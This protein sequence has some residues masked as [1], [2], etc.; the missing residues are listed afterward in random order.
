LIIVGGGPEEGAVRSLVGG[1]DWVHL[2]GPQFGKSKAELLA[3][4]DVF[5][6]PGRVGLAILDAFAAGLPMLSTRLP[7]HGPEMEYLEEGVN[8][9]TSEP[10]VNEY[11]DAV[12]SVL[13]D[14]GRLR[15]LQKGAT[16]SSEKYSIEKMVDNFKLG[17]LASLNLIP[18][19]VGDYV[20]QDSKD[21]GTPTH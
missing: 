1:L 17:I 3:L 8:G 19:D 2:V 9:L 5:L 20:R 7:I 12:A 6:L 21:L 11:A 10:G 14:P 4:S 16:A 18:V 15:K 13:V